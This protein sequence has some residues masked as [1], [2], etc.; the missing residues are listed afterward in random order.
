M[1]LKYKIGDKVRIHIRNGIIN[2]YLSWEK[3][4]GCEVKSYE[5]V[6][7]NKDSIAG[8][9]NYII[10]VPGGGFGSWIGSYEE[11]A[12]YQID[13]KYI[14]KFLRKIEE[15]VIIEKRKCPLC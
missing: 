1:Q 11:F 8:N 4:I 7:I 2:S 15:I 6:G 13:S 5:I 12:S 10:E 14:G 9:Y 3:A